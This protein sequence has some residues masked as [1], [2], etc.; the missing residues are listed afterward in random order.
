MERR[1][2][3]A[4]LGVA[5]S[6]RTS[7]LAPAND[8]GD[9]AS[10]ADEPPTTSLRQRTLSGV[11]WM[12]LT[13]VIAELG[14]F[15][16]SIVLARL[17]APSE[18][19]HTAVA[20]FFAMVAQSVSQQGVGSFLVSHKT[21][22][23]AHFRAAMFVA[24]AGGAIG[25]VL[26][27]GFALTL[28]PPI[29]GARTADFVALGSPVWLLGGLAAVPIAQLQRSL[30]FGRLGL[31]EASASIVSPAA[32][33]VL[34]IGGLQGESMI[35]GGLVAAAV[36]AALGWTLARP[37]APRWHAAETREIVRYGGPA[38]G[39]S[40]LYAATRNIDYLLLAAFIPAFQVGLYMRA[41][42]LGSDYQSKI[43][44]ILLNIAFPV[45][46]RA[47]DLGEARR[48]RA[49]MVRVHATVLFPLLFGLIAIA[50]EFVPW[51]YGQR[52]AGA[53]SLTQILALGGMVAAV[54]TGTGPLLMATG[55]PRLLLVYNLVAFV[56]Y[57]IAV[58][59]AVPFGVTA[60]CVAVVAVRWATFV[61]MQYFIVERRVGIP[62]LET[63][64]DDVIPAVTGGLPLL[65]VTA[66]GLRLCLDAGLPTAVAMALPG[67][68]GLALYVVI[69]RVR[70]PA[71]WADVRMLA[72]GFLPSTTPRRVAR[73]V[74]STLRGRRPT[75]HAG[76][77]QGL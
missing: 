45:L 74:A 65:A 11:R 66:L 19:G 7:L 75:E 6:L 38:S 29:F 62:I 51:M 13:R 26:T 69:L 54:G 61:A 40:V 20:V 32:A 47:R 60:V 63:V 33:I 59:V 5:S 58:V 8:I 3:R 23:R 24:L 16:S 41:F 36:T 56:A 4:S 64:R 53:A 39:S 10:G 34:A 57:T 37:T 48:L 73:R 31:I 18:W 12:S 52:W 9:A 15:V 44:Q 27:L 71:T 72:H 30:S 49:R 46:S 1:V 55:H 70:F 68:A 50:P 22:T 42:A 67:I 76:V 14:G 35:I 17:V 28:A 2:A 43:S 21:P 25:T 77:D